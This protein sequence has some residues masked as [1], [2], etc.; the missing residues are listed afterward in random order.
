M[1]DANFGF[2]DV[3]S[4][5]NLKSYG[6][7]HSGD[8]VDAPQG[9]SEFIDIS[10]DKVREQGVRYVVMTLQSFTQQPYADL[11]ECFAGWMA[12]TEAGS[13]EIYDP[14]TVQDRLDLTAETRI[15]I[16]LIIDVQGNQVIWCDMSL[17]RHPQWNNNIHGNLSGIALTLQSL[18][19]LQKPSLYDLFLLHVQ[20]R[21][22]QVG[23]PAEAEVA[24][25]VDRETP[26]HQE[27]VVS[28][29]LA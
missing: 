18:T 1:F 28:Q 21:G 6:G 9:A 27:E 20:A 17:R 5:Y 10:L 11:P 16:P 7:V 12:R 13:G 24:F 15:A 3:V 14:R 23:S 8:I 26:Y 22:A 4:Y 19:N 25:S 29:F 2:K